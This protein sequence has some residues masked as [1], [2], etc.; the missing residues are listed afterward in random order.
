MTNTQQ[1]QLMMLEVEEEDVDVDV[2]VDE[3]E[4]ETEADAIDSSQISTSSKC[5]INPYVLSRLKLPPLPASKM[6][7]IR[8]NPVIKQNAA[9]VAWRT[10]RQRSLAPQPSRLSPYRARR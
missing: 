4:D 5:A 9:T 7:S 6:N 2:D 8:H 3:D 10:R 1:E